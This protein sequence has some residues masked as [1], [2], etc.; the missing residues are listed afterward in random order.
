MHTFLRRL[1]GAA[2]LDSE[3]YEEVEADKSAMGQA[4]MVVVLSSLAAGIGLMGRG[5]TAL[6]SI[7][8]FS[9]LAWVLWAWTAYFIGTRILP[10]ACTE[11]DLGQLLRTTAFAGSPGLLRLLGLLPGWAVPVFVLASIWMLAAFVVA[12]R[13]ALDYT[14]TLRAVAVCFFG[15]LAYS[16]LFILLD[17]LM[18]VVR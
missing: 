10:E 15:W 6:V 5:S 1:I 17:S 12:V 4:V 16:L 3:I 2:K 11:A 9:I 8:V 18:V 7:T 13:Q 14:S